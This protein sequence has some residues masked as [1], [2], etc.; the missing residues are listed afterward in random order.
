MRDDSVRGSWGRTA[1]A[2]L[3]AGVLAAPPPGPA[4]D[5]IPAAS[6]TTAAVAGADAAQTFHLGTSVEDL[7]AAAEA[8]AHELGAV[9]AALD[10]S[11]ATCPPQRLRTSWE[12]PRGH[13]HG[14]YLEPVGP[15]PG[16][17][18]FDVNGV[19]VCA[20]TFAGYLGFEAHREALGWRIYP[21]PAAEPT[22]GP[23]HA[24][25]QAAGHAPDTVVPVPGA[26]DEVISASWGPI[27]PYAPYEPQRT[28]DPTPKP[29]A[30]ALAVLL[31]DALPGTGHLGI[32]RACD[33]GP[34]S[35]HKEGRAFD[36]GV[37]GV[38]PAE[39]DRVLAQLLATDEEGNAH[40]LAR[41]MG[42]MYVIFDGRIWAS[43]RPA[44]GWRAYRGA[45][46]HRDHVHLSLSWEGA[47]GRTSLWR[48]GPVSGLLDGAAATA[49]ARAAGAGEAGVARDRP[50]TAA[51]PPEQ[52]RPAQAAAAT[53]RRSAAEESAGG[54]TSPTR[55]DPAP[56]DDRD[57]GRSEP[58]P[59]PDPRPDPK[60]EPRP[61]PEPDPEPDPTPGPRPDDPTARTIL[62]GFGP[63]TSRAVRREAAADVAATVI[64]SARAIPGLETW[65]V[66][67]SRLD[68]ALA[69]LAE[70]PDV[71]Y[72]EADRRITA[73]TTADDPL[74]PEQWGLVGEH[75]IG[76]PAAWTVTT[77]AREVTVAVIDTGIDL[78]HPDL[79]ANI[80]SNPGEAADTGADDDGNGYVDDVRGW[81]FCAGDPVPDDRDGHGTHVAGT[82]GAVGGNATGVAGVSWQVGLLPLKVLCDDGGDLSD[83]IAAL[84]Y[85]LDAD[86]PISNN[87]WTWAGEPSA[88]MDDAL[89]AAEAAGHLFITPAGN[90]ATAGGGPV[91]PSAYPHGNIISVAATGSDG[92]LWAGSEGDRSAHDLAAPGVTILSTDR[93]GG[94]TTRTGT[95]HATPH[96][97]GTA[98]LLRSLHPDWT[99]QQLR[100]HLLAT[101]RAA[102]DAAAAEA[103]VLDAAT[104]L[105]ASRV[106][107]H[108]A[109]D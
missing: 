29:G 39:V 65:A 70:R 89:T 1:V 95:S 40:A 15:R 94:Y 12:A 90:H 42:L 38:D 68:D 103:D 44:D 3:L 108:D 86:I 2:L 101:A 59:E 36:W 72:A 55:P 98:A 52:R 87:S 22:T 69:I 49:A 82:I 10:A 25:V 84:D 24:T 99:A 16:T 51:A 62:V 26:F 47:L 77:G 9:P 97:A 106:A 30:S 11:G 48:A 5:G 63:G 14:A 64:R 27:D 75:G 43:Y 102:P 46:P 35:E 73:A 71:R 83:A 18:T 13:L 20:G 100:A 80:W 91:H 45:D 21:V 54:T 60:P 50:P 41:R 92:A 53:D 57:P 31:L 23:G 4:V 56:R 105:G 109:P 34:T 67:E 33:V 28:C 76:A 58:T 107:T 61:D 79:A 88:A 104:A 37:A 96:V 74:L 93:G 66:A 7:E 81:D 19:V 78:T 8:L 17:L 85:A 32:V 6:V